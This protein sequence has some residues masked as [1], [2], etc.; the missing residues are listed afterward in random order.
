M[1]YHNTLEA[2]LVPF[3]ILE[4][5]IDDEL[6]LGP[7]LLKL[8]QLLLE[9]GEVGQAHPIIDCFKAQYVLE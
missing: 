7:S 6:N 9:G 3:D 4:E 2:V 5:A 8:H 1:K